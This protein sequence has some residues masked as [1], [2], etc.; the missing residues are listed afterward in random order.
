VH[1]KRKSKY[2]KFIFMMS[3]YTVKLRRI[4]KDADGEF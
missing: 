4:A 2:H 1:K 3:S